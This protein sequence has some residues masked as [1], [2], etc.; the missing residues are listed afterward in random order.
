VENLQPRSDRYRYGEALLALS[1]VLL[2]L[3]VL[4]DT[5]GNAQGYDRGICLDMFN[6]VRWFAPLPASS[7]LGYS[8]HPPLTFLIGRI[9]YGLYPH[10]VEASQ[11][12]STLAIWVAFFSLRYVLRFLGWL[13]TR[14]DRVLA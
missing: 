10:D 11:I 9:V 5:W 2:K 13:W 8:Y 1:V 6:A 7:A 3:Y 12:S 4:Y 14:R